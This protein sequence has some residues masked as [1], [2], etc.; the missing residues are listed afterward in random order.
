MRYKIKNIRVIIDN[1][2]YK[3]NTKFLNFP[4]SIRKDIIKDFANLIEERYKW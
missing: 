2:V 3:V 1:E 4:K